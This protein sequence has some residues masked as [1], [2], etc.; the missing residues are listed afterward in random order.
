MP[1]FTVEPSKQ[2]PQNPTPLFELTKIMSSGRG[3]MLAAEVA[4]MEKKKPVFG[5]K[6]HQ[7]K[8]A[9]KVVQCANAYR[10]ERSFVKAGEMYY[11]A[12]LLY[13]QLGET[14]TAADTA[15][16]SAKMYAKDPTYHTETMQSLHLGCD[17]YKEQKRKMNAAD[18]LLELSRILA[19]EGQ[20]EKC[21]EVVKE[22][23]DLYLEDHA[24][25][26]AASSLEG[27]ADILSER[28]D[29]VQAAELYE[30]ASRMRLQASLTQGSSGPL[31]FRSMLCSM[32]AND[33]VAA[34][35]KLS[36]YLDLNPAW[37]RT[38][39][40]QFLN[41]LIEKIEGQDVEAYDEACKKYQDRSAADRWVRDVLLDLRKYA[42]G[43]LDEGIL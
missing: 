16:N 42:D 28:Q 37:R 9:D 39:E 6:G 24:D 11:K 2:H 5:K 14:P 32:Q 10:A 31:F 43:G 7:Q 38:S 19:E 35:R 13:K 18:L 34:K 23:V 1:A 22:A 40:C 17:L 21:G 3:D 25:A 4:K 27:L 29:Y 33:M 12:A 30:R 8:I 41:E 36:E 26:K 20:V 15:A